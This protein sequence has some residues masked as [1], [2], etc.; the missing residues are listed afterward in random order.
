MIPDIGTWIDRVYATR[1]Y[2]STKA[3]YVESV[4]DGAAITR[5]GRRMEQHTKA[6]VFNRLLRVIGPSD[7]EK[8]ERCNGR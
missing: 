8:C 5:C 7:D 6:K 4:V 1:S 2:N 3:H